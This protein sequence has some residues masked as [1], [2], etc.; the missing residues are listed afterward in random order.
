MY[1]K[2]RLPRSLCLSATP[3]PP[4]HQALARDHVSS[5]A[6][7]A[8]PR[9]FEGCAVSAPT[10]ASLHKNFYQFQ[11]PIRFSEFLSYS[12]FFVTSL[13]LNS[14]AC[15]VESVYGNRMSSLSYLI[16]TFK[17][18]LV[19]SWFASISGQPEIWTKVVLKHLE[20]VRFP[21]LAGPSEPRLESTFR[22][23]LS[24]K[25]LLLSSSARLSWVS[26]LTQFPRQAGYVESQ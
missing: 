20:P 23:E 2:R 13:D 6:G 22:I 7:A 15:R 1:C 4:R 8:L 26:R 16:L 25:C 18:W 21:P 11:I 17:V 19:F 12:V 9:L 14:G 3:G 24:S 10:L 5:Q